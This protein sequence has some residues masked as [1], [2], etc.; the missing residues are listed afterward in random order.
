MRAGELENKAYRY[1]VGEAKNKTMQQPKVWRSTG[2]PN[3]LTQGGTS[4]RMTFDRRH[5]GSTSG[6]QTWTRQV[7]Y[8][9]NHIFVNSEIATSP[10]FRE[11]SITSTSILSL[12][13]P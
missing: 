13:S 12:A 4:D 2:R 11:I 8:P 5:G 10:I 9:I 3:T 6:L 1:P 7:F